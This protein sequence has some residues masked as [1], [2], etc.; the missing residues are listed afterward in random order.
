MVDSV[1]RTVGFQAGERNVFLHILTACNLSCAHCYINPEQHGSN[2]LD[3]ETIAH[4]LDLFADAEKKSNLI[5][6]GGEPTLHPDL[7][8]IISIAKAKG[9]SVT[10][11]SNG[12]LHHDLLERTSP[13]E[14]DYLSFSLDGPDAAVNDPVRGEGVYDVCVAN[15]RRAIAKGFRVSLIYTVSGRNIEALDRMPALLDS[16]GVERFFIQVIGLR[17]ESA[18]AGKGDLQVDR[19]RWFEVVP[20]VAA[21]AAARGI[22]VTW[23]K[24][25]LGDGEVFQCAGN[26]AENY[27]VF[28]NGRVYQCPLCEDYPLHSYCIK[29]GQ[30]QAREGLTEKNFFS[31]DIAEGCVMNKL[32]QPE[33][34]SY[35]DG[36]VEN[37]I[38]CCMLKQEMVGV[39]R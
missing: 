8:E 13:E 34:I 30:L 35:R 2:T 26:V 22:H 29:D 36:V 27:F 4:W 23:P 14:L 15:I 19:R 9:F 17:G 16:L 5:L 37:K 11:D 25:F 33:N 21:D 3:K 32:L 6:L 31:L 28:P 10:V 1:A 39:T 24:V 7:A 20:A 38:S 12:Y 18:K